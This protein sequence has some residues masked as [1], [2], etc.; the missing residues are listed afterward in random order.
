LGVSDGVLALS[1]GCRDDRNTY[2]ALAIST[3][4]KT[5]LLGLRPARAATSLVRAVGAHLRDSLRS[6]LP[7]VAAVLAS[8]GMDRETNVVVPA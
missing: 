6:S 4:G 8:S 5:F 1:H 3:H 2:E 7:P